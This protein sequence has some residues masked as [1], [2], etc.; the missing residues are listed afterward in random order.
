[1]N[2]E[3][4][5]ERMD[6]FAI[7]KRMSQ[8]Q[9]EALWSWNAGTD[10]VTAGWTFPMFSTSTATIVFAISRWMAEQQASLDKT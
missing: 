2:P 1:M 9:R 4:L 6:N 3:E 10:H 8:D 7:W 5:Q